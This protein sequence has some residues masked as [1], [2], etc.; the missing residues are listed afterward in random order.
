MMAVT[1]NKPVLQK[2]D[3]YNDL[4]GWGHIFRDDSNCK[5]GP[6][7]LV[8]VFSLQYTMEV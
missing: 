2:I 4:T 5:K 6:L 8:V 3:A 1:C 7:A